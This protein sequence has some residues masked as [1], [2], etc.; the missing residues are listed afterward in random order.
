M[1][2]KEKNKAEQRYW[3]C[4]AEF[5]KHELTCKNYTPENTNNVTCNQKTMDKNSVIKMVIEVAR[6][7][8]FLCDSAEEC[9]DGYRKV[10]NEEFLKLCDALDSLDGLPEIS[11]TI[12]GTGTAK[13]EHILLERQND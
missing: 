7:S 4:N 5:G 8:H 12:C 2:N 10:D 9:E 13:A 3:C 1:N 11:N 6:L